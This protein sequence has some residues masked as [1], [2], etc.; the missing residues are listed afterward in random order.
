MPPTKPMTS[1]TGLLLTAF[2]IGTTVALL[3]VFVP[4]LVRPKPPPPPPPAR[5]PLSTP[6][7]L[8]GLRQPPTVPAATADVPDDAEVLGVSAGGRHRAYLVTA[9]SRL[10]SH[11]VNDLL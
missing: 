7:I 4:E 3:L 9:L 6:F 2:V 8:P 10:R 11:V 1:K 5:R